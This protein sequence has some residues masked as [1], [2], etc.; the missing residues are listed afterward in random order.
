MEKVKRLAVCFLSVSYTHLVTTV[1]V[2]NRKKPSLE[3]LKIDSI[4]KEPLPYATFRLEYVD[5]QE[6]GTFQSDSEGRIHLSQL[7]PGRVRITEVSSPDGYLLDDKPREILLEPGKTVSLTVD[8][9]KRQVSLSLADV[10]WRVMGNGSFMANAT[11]TGMASG[12]KVTGYTS[13][14][15]YLGEVRRVTLDGSIY[16]VIYEGRALPVPYMKYIL[17]LIHI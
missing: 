7:D 11:Y 13:Q 14:V 5:G 1:T 3:L 9:Y 6:I 16:E 2:E 12:S 4:T 17:S 15:L 8:V 10:D